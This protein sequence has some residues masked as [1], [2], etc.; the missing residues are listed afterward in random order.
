[1]SGAL[2]RAP[3]HAALLLHLL[4]LKRSPSLPVQGREPC[5]Q[6]LTP[7]QGG[8]GETWLLVGWHLKLLLLP[9]LWV[10]HPQGCWLEPLQ[11]L[12]TQP[13]QGKR[14]CS[15]PSP[16]AWRLAGGCCPIAGPCCHAPV[17]TRMVWRA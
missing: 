5:P 3:C 13:D 7:H 14:L 2:G 10:R 16:S 1:M 15:W 9:G 11:Q 12:L 6:R 8:L 4:P 17:E